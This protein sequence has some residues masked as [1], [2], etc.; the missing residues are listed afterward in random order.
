[1]AL[2]T[3]REPGFIV[4]EPTTVWVNSSLILPLTLSF[5]PPLSLFLLLSPCLSR[6][7]SLIYGPL[8]AQLFHHVT[9]RGFHWLSRPSRLVQP[10]MWIRVTVAFARLITVPNT[11]V[12]HGIRQGIEPMV[13]IALSL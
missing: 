1:M 8:S 2:F 9:I 5:S 12:R 10:H 13:T 7:P 11:Q 4:E 6:T 3:Y